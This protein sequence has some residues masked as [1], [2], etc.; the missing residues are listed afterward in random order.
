MATRDIPPEFFRAAFEH[1]VHAIVG[2]D[3]QRRIV[4]ANKAAAALFRLPLEELIGRSGADF[5]LAEHDDQTERLW[6]ILLSGGTFREDVHF[7]TVDGKER[8]I[9]VAGMGNVEPGLHLAILG[10]VTRRK[11]HELSSRRYELLREHAHDVILFIRAKDGV[12]LE[13]NHAAEQAYG[14]SRAELKGMPIRA[15]RHDP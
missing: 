1:S 6:R 4:A 3:D 10:D 15:L 8:E 5:S 9:R 13:A 2:V 14:C 12:I 7:V 11:E